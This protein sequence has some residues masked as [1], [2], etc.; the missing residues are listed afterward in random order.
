MGWLGVL[1]ATVAAMA[2]GAAWYGLLARPWIAANGFTPDQVREIE[3]SRDPLPYAV[4]ALAHAVMALVLAGLLE[5]V[6]AAS[7]ADGMVLGLT[8][9]TGLVATAMAV[10]HRFQLKPWSLTLLDSG[11]YLA[12]LLAQG[13]ILGW[14]AG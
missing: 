10:N 2:I 3:R 6:G 9:W 4:A 11:H 13:A 14:F 1:L 5:A 8:L 12:I 7:V